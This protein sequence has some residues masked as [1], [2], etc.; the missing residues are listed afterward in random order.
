MGEDAVAF[1]ASEGVHS[2]EGDGGYGIGARR[3]GILEGLAAHIEAA[4]G[5]GVG[6]TIEEAAAFWVS[7]AGDGEVHGFLRGIEIT[8]IERGFIGV[9]E[10]ENA[11]DLIVE[12]A[13]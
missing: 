8:R 11:E 3:G 6:R 7:I 2:N 9:E 4:H 10:R 1:V 5:R 12:R 13:S